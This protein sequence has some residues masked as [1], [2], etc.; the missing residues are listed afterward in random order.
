MARS[1]PRNDNS[2]VAR[3]ETRKTIAL[4]GSRGL[5]TQGFVP[6]WQQTDA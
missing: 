4:R 3:L 1:V 2:I 6:S 5:P